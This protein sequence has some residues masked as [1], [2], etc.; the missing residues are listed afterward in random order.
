MARPKRREVR[1]QRPRVS[2]R[3]PAPSR[4][5]D[6]L[7]QRRY[8]PQWNWR[9]FPVFTAFVAGM[10]LVYLVNGGSY[11][12]GGFILQI[13]ALV[14]VAYAIVH[15]IVVN[16]IVAGRARRRDEAIARGETPAEDYE[17]VVE[18]DDDGQPT[19]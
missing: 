17:D 11:N 4:T 18:Y 12:P 15:L 8:T 14:G 9:T 19:A 3:E 2:T 5:S 7:P 1:A 16:V 10:L 6:A 13:V